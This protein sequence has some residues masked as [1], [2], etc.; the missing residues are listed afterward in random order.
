MILYLLT[1]C[2]FILTYQYVDVLSVIVCT[3]HVYARS[4]TLYRA[5]ERHYNL[6]TS[7][8]Y[9]ARICLKGIVSELEVLI[10]YVIIYLCMVPEPAN[11]CILQRILLYP[12]RI[13]K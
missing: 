7:I 13:G 3:I 1:S 9:L 6:H 4:R 8:I 11:T 2:L 5:A 12:I 10:I